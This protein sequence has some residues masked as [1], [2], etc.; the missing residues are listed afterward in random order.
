MT[1]NVNSPD[2]YA[3]FRFTCE[4][5]DFT[6]FLPHPLASAI[7]YIIR[8]PFKGN[9]LE[10]LSKAIFWLEELIK[11]R[12]FWMVRQ[13]GEEDVRVGILN[14]DDSY[15]YIASA[16]GLAATARSIR[17]LFEITSDPFRIRMTD[18]SKLMSEIHS[19][20]EQLKNSE[21]SE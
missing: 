13:G 2:H 6:K 11:T 19:R 12:H 21:P 10:D 1:D 4:P 18:V 14:E 8:A 20:I 7:E 9:E 16:W 17:T 3:R 15:L 5:K